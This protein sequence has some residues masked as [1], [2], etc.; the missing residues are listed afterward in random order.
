MRHSS[1]HAHG[2]RRRRNPPQLTLPPLLPPLQL[3]LIEINTSPALFRAGPVL[4]DLLPRVVEE[5][6]QKCVD[7]YL[8]PPPDTPPDQL[9]QPL[10]GFQR[11]EVEEMGGGP[12]G[13]QAGASPQR[14]RKAASMNASGS[15]GGPPRAVARA[16]SIGR[17]GEGPPVGGAVWR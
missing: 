9:P 1:W 15:S 4:A 17:N 13:S 7:P 10:D 16:G 14:M 2:L 12:R 11:V 8:P 6:V 3:Y 5:C